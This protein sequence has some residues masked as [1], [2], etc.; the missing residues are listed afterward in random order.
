MSQSQVVANPWHLEEEE[1]DT[2]QHAQ[3]IQMHEKHADQ[4]SLTQ[5]RWTEKHNDKTQGKTY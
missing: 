2:N 1:I 3:D 5:A 4:P